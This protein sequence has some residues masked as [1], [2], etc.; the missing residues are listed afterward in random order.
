MYFVS[1]LVGQGESSSPSSSGSPTEWTQGTNSPSE[2]ST[3][4]ARSPIRVMIRIE[5]AT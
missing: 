2:P 3:S 4:S 1:A 5:T